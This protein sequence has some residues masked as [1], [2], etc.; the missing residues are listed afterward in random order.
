MVA[1][2]KTAVFLHPAHTWNRASLELVDVQPLHGGVR[3]LLPS[4]TVAEA[5]VSQFAPGGT[6]TKY[7]IPLKWTENEKAQLIQLCVDHDFLTIQPEMRLGL[8]DEAR[9]SLTLQNHKR[10]KH[11]ITKWAGV[12]NARFDAIYQ[13]MLGIAARTEGTRP[14]PKPFTPLQKW[15]TM[16]GIALGVLLLGLAGYGLARPFVTALW[17]DRFGLLLVLLLHLIAFVL[18]GLAGLAWRERRKPRW[19][20]A[21]THVWTLAGVNLCLFL[22]G[23]GAW[24]LAETAVLIWRSDLLVAAGDGQIWYAILGYAGVI[25]AVLLLVASGQLM[26]RLLTLIDERF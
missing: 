23:V 21:Y 9:P 17:P 12:E 19:D 4:W 11:T 2:N 7:R 8:P 14:F 6:E 20:R 5:T 22:A 24:G 13:A 18:A 3:V 1:E 25:T 26:P 16:A 10:K 15:V